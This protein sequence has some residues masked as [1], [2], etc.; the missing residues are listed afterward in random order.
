VALGEV[1]R[2]IQRVDDER[3]ALAA[4]TSDLAERQERQQ[5]LIDSRLLAPLDSLN[6]QVANLEEHIANTAAAADRPDI[7]EALRTWPRRLESLSSRLDGGRAELRAQMCATEEES[8]RHTAQIQRLCARADESY[9]EQLALSSRL[10]EQHECFTEE[11]AAAREG[12][13]QGA[14]S[15]LGANHFV[16]LEARIELAEAKQR[17]SLQE[18]RGRVDEL[19]KGHL[20][21]VEGEP[22]L[23]PITKLGRELK[24]LM[25]AQVDDSAKALRHMANMVEDASM[26]NMSMSFQRRTVPSTPV[27][28]GGTPLRHSHG[29]MWRA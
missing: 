6:V 1:D 22:W 9:A 25:A 3:S 27:A 2:Q 26:Q 18:M 17:V 28:S 11:V 13:G 20:A 19:N 29:S 10:A 16:R 24:E 21:T 7:V 15:P 5:Q 23:I 4:Q 8:S 14:S 12:G